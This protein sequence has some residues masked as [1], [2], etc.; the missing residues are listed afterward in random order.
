VSLI[1]GA[2][3]GISIRAITE[4]GDDMEL[5]ADLTPAPEG[6]YVAFNPETGTTTQGETV[7]EAL[8][9]LREATELYLEEFPLSTV[10][11]P[12]LTSF[13]VSEHA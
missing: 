11:R 5:S 13:Q 12:L 1:L 8:A 2:P 7:E 9:N 6:G 4:R 10:G 3:L